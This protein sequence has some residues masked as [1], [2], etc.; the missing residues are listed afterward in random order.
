MAFHKTSEQRVTKLSR[1]A[2]TILA[3]V[4][5]GALREGDRLPSEEKLAE[6]YHVSVGT[7]QKALS[8]LANSGVVSREHGRGTFISRSTVAP[9]DLRYLR[10]QDATGNILPSYVHLRSVRRTKR[11]GPWSG[12][13]DCDSFVRIERSI[14]IGTRLE[15]YSEFWLAENDFARLGGVSRRALEKNLRV[16]LSN[17][18]ALPTLRADQWVRVM[19]LPKQAA[20]VLGLKPAQPGL[21]MELR[22]YTLRD[23]AL[24]Y[25]CIYA[26]PFSDRL[27]LA[28]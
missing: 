18:L 5:S 14:T 2:D 26:A 13:L 17:Q 24:Y 4:E 27:V 28:G 10:F 1:I 7:V 22:G 3:D 20:R 21:I 6:K 11:K 25:Q 15:L 9:A 8:R 23:R 19:P 12:F 16:L